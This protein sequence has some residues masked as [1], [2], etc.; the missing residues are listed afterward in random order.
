MAFFTYSL[1]L[2]PFVSVSAYALSDH[3]SDHDGWML[4]PGDIDGI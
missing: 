2:L 4:A 3:W 1:S